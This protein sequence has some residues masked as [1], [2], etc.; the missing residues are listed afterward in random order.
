MA[1]SLPNLVKNLSEDIHIIKCKFGNDD[2]KCE[3]CGIKY[4]YCD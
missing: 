2:K 4:R 1:S 3:T